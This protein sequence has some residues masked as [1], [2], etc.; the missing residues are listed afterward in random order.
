MRT[1]GVGCREANELQLGIEVH[2]RKYST[3]Q[4]GWEDPM[5]DL[6][7]QQSLQVFEMTICC[8]KRLKRRTSTRPSVTEP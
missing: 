1:P 2:S 3:L 6:G 8:S 7:L 4:E 5:T